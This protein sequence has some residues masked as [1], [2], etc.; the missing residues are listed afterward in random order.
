MVHGHNKGRITVQQTSI[1]MVRT[2][3][4]KLLYSKSVEQK[5]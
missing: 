5:Q 1:I 4:L 3:E 2:Q